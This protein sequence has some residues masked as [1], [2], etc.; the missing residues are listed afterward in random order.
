MTDPEE[1]PPCVVV[2]H[3]VWGSD[4][5]ID[6]ACKRLRKLGFA[7]TVPSLYK[8]HEA[9]LVPRNIQKAMAVIWDFSLEERCDKKRVAA[10]AARKGADAQTRD[11]LSVLYDPRFRD[12][13]M[14]IVLDAITEAR[15]RHAKVATLGFSLGGGISLATT[16]RPGHP[17]AAIAYCGEPPN[18]KLRGTAVPMLAICASHDELM[19]PLMPGFI[20]AALEQ[21][22]DLTVKT[23]PGT[24][25][26][27]F[28]MNFKERYN[29]SAAREAWDVTSWFLSKALGWAPSHSKR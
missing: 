10:E 23:F 8:G 20:K 2:L 15:K 6:A 5:N 24:E 13:M 4:S 22:L 25:H 27:F 3:E 14:E 1:S 19:N 16:T 11:V 7:T 21:D 12:G 29:A 17:D 28:N 9:L 26:D 18:A